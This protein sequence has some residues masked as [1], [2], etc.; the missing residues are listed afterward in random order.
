METVA[1]ATFRFFDPHWLTELSGGDNALIK[2]MMSS[3]TRHLPDLIKE[4]QDSVNQGN[5]KLLMEQVNRANYVASLFTQHNLMKRLEAV[6]NADLDA[7][8]THETAQT[9]YVISD[10]LV[11]LKEVRAYQNLA[12]DSHFGIS[13]PLSVRNN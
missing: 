5:K 3:L 11:L 7:L 10:L 9:K 12:L 13:I 8:T 1:E 6:Q 2:N 4:I